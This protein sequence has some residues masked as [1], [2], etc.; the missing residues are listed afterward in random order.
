MTNTT[1]K[2]ITLGE[3]LLSLLVVFLL[4]AGTVV[5][6]GRMLGQDFG[7]SADAE[8]VRALVAAPTAEQ[9]ADL[10]LDKARLLA[11]DSAAWDA[12]DADGNELGSVVSTKPY[13]ADVQGYAGA[14]P[15]YL[16]IDPEGTVKAVIAADNSETPDFFSSATDGVF[17]QITGKSVSALAT[18]EIDAVSGATFS[19][20]SL[21]ANVKQTL[22][23]RAKQESEAIATPTIGWTRTVAVIIVLAIGTFATYRLKGNKKARLVILALNVIV[24]GFWCGQLL[25]VSLLRGLIQNGF[26]PLICL[27][28][29]LML[30]VAIV[31]PLLGKSHHYCRWVCPYGSLQE[32]A[33]HVPVQK[34]HIGRRGSK[35]M[36]HVRMLILVVLLALLWFG[37]A[38][39]LLDYEPF[40]AFL[41]TSAAPAVVVLA[42]AFVVLGAFIQR[43]WCRC[44]CPLGTLLE[45]AE[46]GRKP[47]Q[48]AATKDA[49]TT[50]TQTNDTNHEQV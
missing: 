48:K 8:D 16:Y 10:G 19:S 24:T 28:T 47:A 42:A 32:L 30:L 40:S 33:W 14:T 17:P 4:I 20:N 31:L 18:Q 44:V 15:L 36:H 21:I 39:W 12:V 50:K 41:I 2:L 6:S 29:L 46:D 43:P 38:T 1:Q 35:I 13:A 11:A 26:D 49:G 34:I 3:R 27:P 37:T 45:L 25:S 5:W 9:L 22:A 23:A 7:Q